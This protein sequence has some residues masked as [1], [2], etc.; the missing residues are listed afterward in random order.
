MKIFKVI[1]E[2][3]LKETE[4]KET[5]QSIICEKFSEGKNVISARFETIFMDNL[6]ITLV[7]WMKHKMPPA[8]N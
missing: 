6:I 7:S 5:F 1:G 3:L 4:P 8:P 2:K